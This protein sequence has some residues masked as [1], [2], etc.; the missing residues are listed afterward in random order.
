MRIEKTRSE[1]RREFEKKRWAPGTDADLDLM[2]S[3]FG[4]EFA[5]EKPKLPEWFGE[6]ELAYGEVG[7]GWSAIV[8]DDPP[9]V[10]DPE[11]IEPEDTPAVV[12][13]YNRF[14]RMKR[15]LG[16]P[17]LKW[18]STAWHEWD[19]NARAALEGAIHIARGEE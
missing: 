11:R 18:E 15:V 5:P 6:R 14:V 13:G 9:R 4:V 2:A 10:V 17:N 12:E 16:R 1:V 3:I 8:V 19:R 7:D